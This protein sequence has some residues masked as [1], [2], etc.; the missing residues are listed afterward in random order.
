MVL[1]KKANFFTPHHLIW[2][3]LPLVLHPLNAYLA[4]IVRM[5]IARSSLRSNLACTLRGMAPTPHV[6]MLGSRRMWLETSLTSAGLSTL[7][8]YCKSTWSLSHSRNACLLALTIAFCSLQWN[9]AKGLFKTCALIIAWSW[10]FEPCFLADGHLGLHG[11][12]VTLWHIRKCHTK[13]YLV[14]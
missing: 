12:M 1:C 14:I 11:S 2:C 4:W 9:Q 5:T 8:V 10:T 13:L 7:G 6:V 3:R